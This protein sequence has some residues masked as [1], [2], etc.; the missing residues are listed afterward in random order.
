MTHHVSLLIDGKW[1]EGSA[2]QTIDV[3]NPATEEVCATVAKAELADLEKAT[4]AA[5]RSFPTWSKTSPYDRSHIMR[6]A[7]DLLRERRDHIAR[8]LTIEN[9]KPISQ[10]RLEVE[11]AADML[12]W[13]AEEGRRSYGRVIAGRAHGVHQYKIS[14]PVGPVAAFTPWN[15]PISQVV[16]KLAAALAAGCTLVIKAAEETPA[17]A[18]ELVRACVDAGIPEGAVNLVFGLPSEIS[19]YLIPHP[20]IRKVSFTGSTAVGKQLASLAGLHMKRATM[21]LGGH[22]PAIVF[23][24]SDVEQAAKLIA[25]AKYRN[26]GQVC[27]APTRLMV[28]KPVYDDFMSSF[29]K[30]VD[31]IKVGNGLDESVT[32]GPLIHGRRLQAVE[33]LVQDAARRGGAIHAGGKRMGNAG[34]FLEPTV[35]SGTPADAEAM[36]T[37]VFGPV[38]LVGTFA[39]ADDAIAEANRLPYG[40]ASY[41]YTRSADIIS[42]MSSAIESGIVAFNHT[43]VALPETPFGGIKDSGH[44]SEGGVEGLEAYLNTKFVTQLSA[45]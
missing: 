36:N 39:E 17:S 45:A 32:M 10:A 9:G 44:G 35:I 24:D 38:A 15:F 33:E 25:A 29:L 3:I 26:A 6:R 19:E 1:T 31:A 23:S 37:E 12:D 34:Y 30:E 40:L 43:A 4:Q 5:S 11:S 7:A 13:F 28:Q 42:R 22:A 18:A 41:V 20:L 16:K 27:I 8:L 21:E 14:E 2:G